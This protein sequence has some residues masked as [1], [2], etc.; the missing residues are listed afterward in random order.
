MAMQAG[1]MAQCVTVLVTKPEHHLSLIPGTWGGRR[2][3]SPVFSHLR[4]IHS[5]T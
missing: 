4:S 2:E 5:H 1:E 3:P